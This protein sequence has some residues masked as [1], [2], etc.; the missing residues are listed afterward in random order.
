MSSG[1]LGDFL[2][3]LIG[4]GNAGVQLN[5]SL[6]PPAPTAIQDPMGRPPQ[7]GPMPLP[8][9]PPPQPSLGGQLLPP[10]SNAGVPMQLP[11]PPTIPRKPPNPVRQADNRRTNVR[12]RVGT[13]LVDAA[14]TGNPPAPPVPNPQPPQYQPPNKWL[15]IGAALLGALSP[16]AGGAMMGAGLAQGLGAGAQQR[17]TAAQQAYQS[18]EQ[19]RMDQIAANQ[20]GYNLQTGQPIPASPLP[21]SLSRVPWNAPGAR[22]PSSQDLF[23]HYLQVAAHYAA[24]PGPQNQAASQ[25]FTNLANAAAMGEYHFGQATYYGNRDQVYLQGIQ[26]RGD[27]EF[28]RLT[29][30][31]RFKAQED[32]ARLSAEMERTVYSAQ[33]RAAISRQVAADRQRYG[34]TEEQMR[35]EAQQ[36]IVQY[37]QQSANQRNAL[38]TGGPQPSLAPL[39]PAQEPSPQSQAPVVSAP[40][41]PPAAPTGGRPAG[42][43]PDATLTSG[44]INGKPGRAWYESSTGKAWDESGHEIH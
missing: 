3:S 29:G 9:L 27:Q 1:P 16:G 10:S 20:A 32:A 12:R 8:N 2:Q 24:L 14:Q 22:Q 6:T 17:Y 38:T 30:E 43:P 31:Q 41:P 37:Q 4:Q 5:A 40:P 35:L 44:M 28:A 11:V 19:Q 7:Q 36:L 26:M 15:E 39:P 18:G 21:A 42:V 25:H 23:N 13:Q 33:A 34:L